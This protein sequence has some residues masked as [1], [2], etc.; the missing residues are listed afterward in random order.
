MGF[1][2]D[3]FNAADNTNTSAIETYPEVSFTPNG[4]EV[5]LS[6]E[7]L[8]ELVWEFSQEELKAQ[9]DADFNAQRVEDYKIQADRLFAD[10]RD[11]H[12]AADAARAAAGVVAAAGAPLSADEI[13]KQET[14]LREWAEDLEG[15]AWQTRE[16][17]RW[18]RVDAE[19]S[20]KHAVT[21]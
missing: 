6:P 4:G 13:L 8:Q 15:D 7:A 5:E 3:I 14:F 2:A 9:W 17:G 10:A 21:L 20:L 18:L 11:F 1:F 16:E 12:K 19:E